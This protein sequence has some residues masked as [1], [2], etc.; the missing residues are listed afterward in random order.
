MS[1]ITRLLAGI[2]S[3]SLACSSVVLGLQSTVRGDETEENIEIN[4]KNFPDEKFRKELLRSSYDKDQDGYFSPEEISAITKIDFRYYECESLKGIEYFT[5]LT[6][7]DCSYDKLT[8]LDVSKN[9]KLKK[10]VCKENQITSL[11]LRKNKDLEILDCH[12][13]QISSLN[14][15]G[16]DKLY[17]LDSVGNP[18][19][20]LE[21][22]KTPLLFDAVKYGTPSKRYVGYHSG[23]LTF[24]YWSFIYESE[25]DGVDYS[26]SIPEDCKVDYEIAINSKNFPDPVLLSEIQG[27]D[28]NKN[29][30]LDFEEGFK[31]DSLSFIRRDNCTDFRGIEYLTALKSFST[32]EVGVT[33]LDVTHNKRLDDLSIYKGLLTSIDVSH[34]PELRKLNLSY[35]PISEVDVSANPNL[36]YLYLEFTNITAIDLTHNPKIEDLDIS[37]TNITEL[38]LYGCPELVE[39]VSKVEPEVLTTKEGLKYYYYDGDKAGLYSELSVNTDVKLILTQPEYTVSFDANGGSGSMD[40][41]IIKK[42][43]S[44]VL[45]EC[46]FNAPE[47]ME[48]AGWDLGAVGD[49]IVIKADTQIKATWAYKTYF[50]NVITDGNGTA[51][52]SVESGIMGTEVTLTATPNEGYQFKEWTVAGDAVVIVDNKF[53]IGTCNLDIVAHFEPI[54]KPDPDNPTPEPGSDTPVP[55]PNTPDP[56]NPSPDPSNPSPNPGNPDP[57]K[58]PSFE[59]FVERLYVVALGRASEPEGKA[60]W[61]DQVVNK[62]FTGADCA[63][64]FMLGAPEFLGRNLTDDEFVEVLYKTYFDRDS[65]PDGKAYWMGR[66][67]SGTERAILVE[68][69]IESVEWCNVCASY[70]VKSGALYHKA[71]V[72]SKNAVKFATR[73]YTCCLGRDPEEDG[74]SYWALALTNLDATGY[75]A[76]SLFFT[77]PEF[78]GLNTTNEEYLTRLYKTFMGREP[79]ADG[80][81]YW[82]GLLNGGTDRVDVMKAFAGCPEFQEICNQYGIVRGEI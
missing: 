42:G 59:D 82:L 27:C 24:H 77:L 76:A 80:F 68:E 30:M 37:G 35:N 69:F 15:N 1:K 2:L 58:E 65:E 33:S 66:L 16:C 72:P 23:A 74:L 62:G 26:L 75:Q 45:P 54:Q 71:T 46:T 12:L 9:T 70:G 36:R 41:Q 63:R 34:N 51:S 31:Y 6:E 14:V 5:E 55:G 7:L 50:I 38:D 28:S 20:Y 47:G 21:I 48:F 29:G 11:D 13:N 56:S 61:V 53:T 32:S 64:F 73:L 25:A 4:E 10:L 81:A 57:A 52:A 22:T 17:D 67:A 39:L 60:F 19:E 3:V 78:V 44:I 79:E 40:P 43:E 49:E 18:L 8:S